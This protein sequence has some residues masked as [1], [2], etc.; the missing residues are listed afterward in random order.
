MNEL[1]RGMI[2]SYLEG[3]WLDFATKHRANYRGLKVLAFIRLI[4]DVALVLFVT[5]FLWFFVSIWALL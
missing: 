3:P 4:R 2:E 5:T 1:N